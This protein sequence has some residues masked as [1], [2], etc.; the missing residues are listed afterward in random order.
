D[1][2]SMVAAE[3][4]AVQLNLGHGYGAARA[5]GTVTGLL[6]AC[7]SPDGAALLVRTPERFLVWNVNRP[8]GERYEWTNTDLTAITYWSPD[9][10]RLLVF[11][12]IGA[13]LVDLEKKANTRVGVYAQPHHARQGPPHWRPAPGSPWS[14]DRGNVAFVADA[15]DSWNGARLGTP[16]LYVAS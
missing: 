5:L 15:G 4:N 1:L 13:T 16:G 14:P 9:S 3:N 10:K 2:L 8:G 6:D 11:D 7:F 12:A